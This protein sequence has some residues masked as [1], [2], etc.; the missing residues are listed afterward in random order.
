MLKS[1]LG[2]FNHTQNA[3]VKLWKRYH[4][5][6]YQQELTI[7]NF[8]VISEDIASKLQKIVGP[9]FSSFNPFPSLPSVTTDDRKLP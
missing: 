7:I 2:V 8:L 6:F 4:Y 3:P 9:I 1:L 5:E